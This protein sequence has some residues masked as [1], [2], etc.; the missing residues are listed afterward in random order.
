MNEIDFLLKFIKRIYFLQK[1]III[2]FY[3]Y[4]ILWKTTHN[5]YHYQRDLIQINKVLTF[6]YSLIK[7]LL[8]YLKLILSIFK[9]SIEYVIFAMLVLLLELAFV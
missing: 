1:L 2:N 4:S 7:A 9:M 8:P 3:S 6:R 5:S